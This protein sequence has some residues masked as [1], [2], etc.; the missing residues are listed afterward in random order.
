MLE[1]KTSTMDIPTETV[2]PFLEVPPHFE[3]V[4]I[5]AFVHKFIFLSL[6]FVT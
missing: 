6:E 5:D 2:E 4:I 3:N 1:I